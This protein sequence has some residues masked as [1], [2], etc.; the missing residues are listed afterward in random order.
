MAD[1]VTIRTLRLA[2]GARLL[3]FASDSGVDGAALTDALDGAPQGDE[4]VL[5][6]DGV[7]PA[8]ARRLAAALSSSTRVRSVRAPRDRRLRRRG[9]ALS[10]R[11][12]RA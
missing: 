3:S 11:A 12:E 7:D 4:I 1:G 8:H 2:M 6:L 9:G 5:N 10:A